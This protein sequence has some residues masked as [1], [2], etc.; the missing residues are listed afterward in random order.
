MFTKVV[1]VSKIKNSLLLGAV[2][3][4]AV[5]LLRW[6]EAAANGV[7]RG[8]SI[9]STVIIPSLFPFL[10][11]SGF[12]VRTGISAAIGRRLG[13]ITQA[14]FRLPG[15]C[16]PGILLSMIGGYPTGASAVSELYDSGALT[17][18]QARRM[19]RFCV[20]GGPAFV[21]SAVGSGLMGSVRYG[22]VLY[23]AQILTM[24]LIGFIDSRLS[25]RQKTAEQAVVSSL[26]VTTSSDAFVSSVSSACRTLLTICGF[27]VL[28]AS[29]LSLADASGISDAVAQVLAWPFS[30]SGIDPALFS[31][32]LPGALEVSCGCVEAA[33]LKEASPMLLGALIGWGGLSVHCQIAASLRGRQLMG[34]GYF[35]ARVEHALL[36]GFFSA[37][38]L[39]FVPIP[40]T[41]SS[42]VTDIRPFATS[43]TVSVALLMLC[44]SVLMSLRPANRRDEHTL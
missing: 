14:L 8:L 19:L 9:C 34:G 23:A 3:L 42:A 25:D 31:C 28:F 32:L 27:V 43:A 26:P 44:A 37:I 2:L 6:P 11:L 29:V 38:L 7:S 21:I 12:L 17:Q 33:G 16:A 22:L 36:S 18:A 1:S 35:L 40:I 30:A 41:V 4:S 10:V 39:K 20:G 13:R 5:A 15:C 24:F